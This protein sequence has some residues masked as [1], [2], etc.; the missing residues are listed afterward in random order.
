[1]LLIAYLREDGPS[2]TKAEL[3]D[4]IWQEESPQTGDNNFR[5][6]V[7]RLR[8]ALGD[9]ATIHHQHGR[10]ELHNLK[11]DVVF[12]LAALE[13]LDFDVAL[14]WYKGSF[15]KGIDV[16][17]ADIIRAQ[18]WQNFRD[19]VLRTSFETPNANLLERLHHLEPLDIGILERFL[20]V[21]ADD[22]FRTSQT[23]ERAK[24]IFKREVG[25][26]PAE[27]GKFRA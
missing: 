15:L 24:Q 25:E 11:A 13:R 27:F 14:G 8:D 20:E 18:L 6:Y 12:F 4:A 23:L 2:I 5:V 26:V 1:M 21:I 22:A 16:P 3:I 19:T 17:E 7:K 10:Y 9:A